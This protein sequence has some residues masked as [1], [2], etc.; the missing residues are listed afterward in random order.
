MRYIT[1]EKIFDLQGSEIHFYIGN[2]G[3]RFK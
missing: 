3:G 1:D 2:T